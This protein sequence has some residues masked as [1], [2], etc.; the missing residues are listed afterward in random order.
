VPEKPKVAHIISRLCIGG[1][2]TEVVLTVEALTRRGY[3]C[4][5]LAGDTG[6]DE[7]SIEDIARQR[8]LSLIRVQ[9]LSREASF[10]QGA[11]ALFSLVRTFRRQRPHIVHTHTAK[12]GALGRLAARL[13]GVPVCI[14]TFHGHV[15]EGH[16]S[17][18]KAK[19]YLLIERMLAKWSDCVVAV[20]ETQRH[21]FIEK[22][23]LASASNCVTI[24]IAI[25][26]APFLAVNGYRGPVRAA[27]RCD[28]HDL[29]VAWIGRMSRVKNPDLF[30][31]A[32]ALVSDTNPDTRF[33][34]VGDGELRKRIDARVALEPA[35][36]SVSR[37]GW[38]HNLP[39]LYSDVDLVVLTSNHE[40]MPLVLVEAMASGRPFIATAVG[41]V[42]DL[43]VGSPRPIGGLTVFENGI[44]AERSADSIAAAIR[45]A[46]A[47]RGNLRKMG[48]SG[49]DFAS[50]SFTQERLLNDIEVLYKKL[51]PPKSAR[52]DRLRTTVSRT[53]GPLGL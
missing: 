2:S 51:A 50:R 26:M 5:L 30:L 52:A 39:E 3:E 24:P 7:G 8:G 9:G 43:M 37:I 4:L 48:L 10:W 35:L 16:F 19:T 45:Y 38:I 36:S 27:C 42:R 21:E 22:Y 47:H 33:A 41:G 13:A 29:L 11:A 1:A 12:A 46:L 34:V 15:F 20:C 40:G 17:A 6:R 28:K 23:R 53:K 31:D 14:H 18:W 32:A 49:R 25:E 44:I